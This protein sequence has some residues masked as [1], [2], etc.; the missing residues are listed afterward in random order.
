MLNELRNNKIYFYKN[1]LKWNLTKYNLHLEIV[2]GEGSDLDKIIKNVQDFGI[3]TDW[4]FHDNNTKFICKWDI[5]RV[6]NIKQI[7]LLSELLESNIKK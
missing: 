1:I 6:K 3:C 7:E 2:L 4:S 5:R